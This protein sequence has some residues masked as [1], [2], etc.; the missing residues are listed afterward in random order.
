[1]PFVTTKH[2]KRPRKLLK[3]IRAAVQSG[4]WKKVNWLVVEW[5]RSYEAKRL[6]VRLACRAMRPH[7]R[8][9]KSE[10]DA[11]AKALDAWEG[12][13]EEVAVDIRRKKNDPHD[14]RQTMTFGIENRALQY[15]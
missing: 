14:F 9:D 13:K 3:R 8:P 5:L 11:F 10:L 4:K 15:L 6:A 2:R 12:T 1:M 7:N